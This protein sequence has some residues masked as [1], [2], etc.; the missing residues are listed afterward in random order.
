M[1]PRLILHLPPKP[2]TARDRAR[3][4]VSAARRF[5][6]IA[7]A[8]KRDGVCLDGIRRVQQSRRSCMRAARMALAGK[9]IGS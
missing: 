2:P 9:P 5:S 6:R 1:K 7:V 4:L 3:S 8:A